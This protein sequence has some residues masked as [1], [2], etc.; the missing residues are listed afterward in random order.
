MHLWCRH[1][2]TCR[3]SSSLVSYCPGFLFRSSTAIL[4]YEVSVIPRFNF[5]AIFLERI[6]RS[7]L[8]VNLQALS[9][10]AENSYQGDQSVSVTC[11][12]TKAKPGSSLTS[13]MRD[14][15][16]AI[17][18]ENKSSSENLKDKFVKDT[19]GPLAPATSDVSNNWGIFGKACRLDKPCVV[20]E[21]HLRRF[22]GLLVIDRLY[23]M[24]YLFVRSHIILVVPL[25]NWFWMKENGGVHRC[26][27]ASITVKAPVREVWNV[28]TAY[29]SLPE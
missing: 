14:I 23:T 15:D 28:L 25:I 1:I 27:V 9:Y 3:H 7:D 5:P 12:N 11:A 6:I 2:S 19:F 8:P 22:D 17:S 13:V 24:T 29:E 4:S 21:V 18:H 26:V 10:R 20:D 16:C